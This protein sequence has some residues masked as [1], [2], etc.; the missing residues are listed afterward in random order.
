MKVTNANAFRERLPHIYLFRP[1]TICVLA[2]CQDILKK[3]HHTH[4][5]QKQH[6]QVSLLVAELDLC[7]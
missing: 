1:M 6:E 3:E 4:I 5:N 7:C 2:S